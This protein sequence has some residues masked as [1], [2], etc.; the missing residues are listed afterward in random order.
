M[1]PRESA[2]IALALALV[3]LEPVGAVL[4]AQTALPGIADVSGRLV[5]VRF[6]TSDQSVPARAARVY[7]TRFDAAATK[8]VNVELEAEFEPPRR[9][10]EFAVTCQYTKPDGGTMGPFDVK[11]TIQ[12]DWI[13]SYPSNGWGNSAGGAFVPGVYRVRCTSAGSVVGEGMFEMVNA[14]AEIA[15]ANAKFTGMRFFESPRPMLAVDDRK[16]S[17][18]F[19]AA[20]TRS[21]GVELSFSHPAPGRVVDFTVQCQYFKPDGSDFGKFDIQYSIQPDWRSIRHANIWGYE[22]AGNYTKGVYRVACSS[23]GKWIAESR[24]EIY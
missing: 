9:Q 7:S 18:A 20:T 15:A 6:F 16:Y 3:A 4:E 21:V 8:Y 23:D 22:N 11:F 24:F 12:P 10:V 14:P 13:R 5:A 2:L 19:E 17:H 1:P